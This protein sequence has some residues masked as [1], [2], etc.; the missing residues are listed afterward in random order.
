MELANFE[1]TLC[2][3]EE[4]EEDQAEHIESSNANFSSIVGKFGKIVVPLD[5]ITNRADLSVAKIAITT[6]KLT[7]FN[8]EILV[9]ADGQYYQVG[10]IEYEDEP[11][12]PFKFDE[13]EQPYAD[14]DR[15]GK[16]ELMISE[17]ENSNF[18]DDEEG[19][20]GTW[21]NDI[22]EVGEVKLTET[23]TNSCESDTLGPEVENM[24]VETSIK[25]QAK[26]N[27]NG[28]IIR[29]AALPNQMDPHNLG[30]SRTATF[31]TVLAQSRCFG[32]FPSFVSTPQATSQLNSE[33]GQNRDQI[34]FSLKRR[35]LHR[36]P[37]GEIL[38]S[39]PTFPLIFDNEDNQAPNI[40]SFP[41]DAQP[42][43]PANLD[44][45]TP[46]IEA[47]TV[48]ASLIGFEIEP[49]NNILAEVLGVSGVNNAP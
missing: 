16:D 34:R 5:H 45:E 20:S 29:F 25:F 1:G 46:E 47:T 17:S 10:I 13:E 19:V 23:P 2:R 36:S 35:R 12:F 49:N 14:S 41:I 42:N 38:P 43:D 48:V 11:W 15:E 21:I 6:E 37:S 3:E 33:N 18:N 28:H 32:P 26:S 9:E 24:G 44:V 8:E 39:F 7:K 27:I 4:E 30:S 31:P 22:E 40:A